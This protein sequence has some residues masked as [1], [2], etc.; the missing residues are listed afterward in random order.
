MN[1]L[2]TL[3]RFIL[4]TKYRVIKIIDKTKFLTFTKITEEIFYGFQ[5]VN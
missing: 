5:I 3:N 2:D 1:D 4:S